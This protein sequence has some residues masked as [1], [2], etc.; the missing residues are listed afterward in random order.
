MLNARFN[1]SHDLVVKASNESGLLGVLIQRLNPCTD[2]L[3]AARIAELESQSGCGFCIA[4][5]N[6]ANEDCSL[7]AVYRHQD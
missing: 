2:R 6:R 1:P 5:L 7:I 3:R 4:G